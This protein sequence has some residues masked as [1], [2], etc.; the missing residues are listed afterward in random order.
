MFYITFK[1]LFSKMFLCK[2]KKMAGVGR[3]DLNCAPLVLSLTFSAELWFADVG[4]V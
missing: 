4:R 1:G 2:T 3:V